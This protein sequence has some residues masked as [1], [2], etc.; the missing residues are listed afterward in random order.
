MN[1]K[2]AGVEGVKEL[3]QNIISFCYQVISLPNLINV[4]YFIFKI[5]MYMYIF[6]YVAK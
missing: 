1:L 6:F 3:P 4:E 5:V 2:L